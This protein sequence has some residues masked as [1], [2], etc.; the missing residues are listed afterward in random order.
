MGSHSQTWLANSTFPSWKLD[1]KRS[2][3]VENE[4][5]I[6]KGISLKTI[7]RLDFSFVFL[8]VY[9]N[10]V[11]LSHALTIRIASE[12]R[13]QRERRGLS[14]RGALCTLP[15]CLVLKP[16]TP[17]LS[18]SHS[19]GNRHPLLWLMI[20]QSQLMTIILSI[21]SALL[22]L[23]IL[24]HEVTSWPQQSLQQWVWWSVQR[25]LMPLGKV[26]EEWVRNRRHAVKSS[27][28]SGSP[29][30]GAS[31]YRVVFQVIFFHKLFS[32][33]KCSWIRVAL[34][35]LFVSGVQ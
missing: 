9:V 31:T 6:W 29:W 16:L 30:L 27:Q 10:T 25:T 11:W 4:C 34:R 5:M 14:P 20:S 21:R 18:W 13:Q 32:M 2:H 28:S 1:M 8:T 22:S 24:T 7:C 35:Y 23:F 12:W 19:R 17:H 15:V 3:Q 33:L 26:K